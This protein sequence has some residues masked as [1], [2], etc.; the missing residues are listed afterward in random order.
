MLVTAGPT[1]EPLDPVRVISNASSGKMGFEIAGR[2]F[3]R[4]AD[5]VLVTGPTALT[6][7]T[8]IETARVTTTEE[9]RAAVA[10]YLPECDVLVMAAAPADYRAVE[11]SAEK[12]PRESGTIDVM[13]EPTL[14]VLTST[15]GL[16]RSDAVSVGFALEMGEG[17]ERAREKL[18]RK[19]LDLIVLNR[20]DE[21]GSGFEVDTNRVTL[22]TGDDA[23]R[24]DRMTKRKVAERVLDEI[25]TLL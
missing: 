18:G 20:A 22:V 11:P 19:G 15:V 25:E 9:L 6:N 8:G 7:L 13:L 5:V 14:D 3:A 2:A 10:R 17:V 16:R 1:R 12:R 23:R 24:L 4:G 21:E